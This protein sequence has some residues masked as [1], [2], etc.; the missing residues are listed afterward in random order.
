MRKLDLN[1][2]RLDGIQEVTLGRSRIFGALLAL[3]MPLFTIYFT[4][5][6]LIVGYRHSSLEVHPLFLMYLAPGTGA[7]IIWCKR[8]TVPALIALRTRRP[9]LV[10]GDKVVILGKEYQINKDTVLSFNRTIISLHEGDDK[11]A[12]VPSYFIRIRKI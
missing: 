11:I 8:Y 7:L 9:V 6:G 12:R 5:G 10:R 1:S 2:L 4:I 3:G